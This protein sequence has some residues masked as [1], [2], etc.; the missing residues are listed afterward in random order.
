MLMDDFA[1]GLAWSCKFRPRLSALDDADGTTPWEM[2]PVAILNRTGP[3]VCLIWAGSYFDRIRSSEYPSMRQSL[4][5]ISGGGRLH[6]PESEGQ[7]S[8]GLKNTPTF[9]RMGLVVML[10][11]MSVTR[12]SHQYASPLTRRWTNLGAANLPSST[13][14]FFW[15]EHVRSLS[16]RWDGFGSYPVF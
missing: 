6:H 8:S 4:L 10:A 12:S 3:S 16:F 13:E 15:N 14:C 5:T 9:T 11:A 1:V 2:I 7:S